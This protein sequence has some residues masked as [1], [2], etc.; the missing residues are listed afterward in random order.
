MSFKYFLISLCYAKCQNILVNDLVHLLGH[1]GFRIK[2]NSVCGVG[3]D[4]RNLCHKFNSQ[5]LALRILGLRVASPKFQGSSSRVLGV[6]IPCSKVPVPGFQFQGP[7]CQSP[8][9]PE[10]QSPSLRVPGLRVL[11]LR[12]L[13]LRNQGPGFQVS[14]PDF[15][16]CLCR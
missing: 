5:G 6:R 2:V 8:R 4:S 3:W 9:V 7:V 13:G 14:D 12:V 11:G 16:L 1:L 15:R 10:S